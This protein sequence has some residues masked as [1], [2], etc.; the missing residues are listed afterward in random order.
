[1]HNIAIF[2]WHADDD[3]CKKDT[4]TYR[5]KEWQRKKTVDCDE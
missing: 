3:D 2:C 4:Q 1:M 5:R